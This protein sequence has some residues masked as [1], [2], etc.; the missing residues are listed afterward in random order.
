MK[1]ESKRTRHSSKRNT[2]SGSYFRSLA[3]ED[4]NKVRARALVSQI[5][6]FLKKEDNSLLAFEEVRSLLNP[7]A[8]DSRSLQRVPLSLIVGSEG[9]YR[10][11][12]KSFLPKNR[13]LRDRWAQV[14]EALSR[15]YPLPPVALYKLGGVYFVHDGNHRVSVAKSKG[16]QFI[17]A[18][19]TSISSSIGIDPGMSL[20]EI[21]KAVIEIERKRFE[22]ATGL[23]TTQKDYGIVFTETG[24]Y[25]DIITHLKTLGYVS[26]NGLQTGSL[27]LQAGSLGLQA[28]SLGLQTGSLGL[29]A[30]SLKDASL[31][32]CERVYKPIVDIIREE[33]LLTFFP[34]RTEADLY[35][36][37]V[38]HWDELK[39]K[40][41]D[42]YPIRSAA[43]D[44]KRSAFG[45]IWE[46]CLRGIRNVIKTLAKR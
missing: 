43:R 3:Y 6:S 31:H 38:R 4:F 32:W 29:Q 24:R 10:D 13:A 19:V 16:L 2:F 21:K 17:E 14:D 18:Q 44:L 37:L 40:Y 11:F 30:G 35:I 20:K 34:E 36:W 42:A 8:E 25:D 5:I 46:K 23:T 28:G 22:D 33:R 9:R 1:R 12:T 45:G 27:G 39:R 26:N 15:G 41:G 7:D